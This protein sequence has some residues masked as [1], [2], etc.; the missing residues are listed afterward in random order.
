M[1][2]EWHGGW[3]GL[4]RVVVGTVGVDKAI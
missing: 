3:R 1:P 4:G 2:G